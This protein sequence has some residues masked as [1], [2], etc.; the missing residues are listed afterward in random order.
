M[1]SRQ[2]NE[3]P[4]HSGD[5]EGTTMTNIRT[6]RLAWPAASAA[7]AVALAVL[8]GSGQFATSQAAAA[9]GGAMADTIAA[10]RAVAEVGLTCT[11]SCA[12]YRPGRYGPHCIKYVQN[13]PPPPAPTTR[14]KL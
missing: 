6:R 8:A 2:V 7:L 3:R 9:N 10:S 1:L 12:E 11:W 5:N 13:C 14:H 4:I